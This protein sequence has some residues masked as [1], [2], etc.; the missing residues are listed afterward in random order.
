MINPPFSTSF[1][2]GNFILTN[3]IDPPI[4]LPLTK[5]C[6]IVHQATVDFISHVK[7]ALLLGATIMELPLDLLTDDFLAISLYSQPS[8]S[9]ILHSILIDYWNQVLFR[10]PDD[11]WPLFNSAGLVHVEANI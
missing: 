2:N 1:Y 4:I 10:P 6:T 11:G 3:F 9:Q 8:N 5:I 7:V